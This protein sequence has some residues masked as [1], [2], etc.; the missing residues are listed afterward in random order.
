MCVFFTLNKTPFV[1]F[2]KVKSLKRKEK[3]CTGSN[4]DFFYRFVCGKNYLKLILF[5]SHLF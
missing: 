5:V 1:G 3:H 4:L 2:M